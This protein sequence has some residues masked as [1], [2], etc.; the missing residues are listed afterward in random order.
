MGF[1]V[2]CAKLSSE[3]EAVETHES[4]PPV[5]HV[6]FNKSP[7]EAVQGKRLRNNRKRRDACARTMKNVV[8]NTVQ[9]TCFGAWEVEAS[10]VLMSRD[11]SETYPR[12]LQVVKKDAESKE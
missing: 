6:S 1:Q 8:M 11:F 3:L 9:T 2:L 4:E 12:L 5:A 7:Q 10:P